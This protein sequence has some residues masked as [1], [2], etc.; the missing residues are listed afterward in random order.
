MKKSIITL[1]SFTLLSMG[2]SVRSQ[3]FQNFLGKS[4]P[5]EFGNAVTEQF[6]STFL[7]G[8]QY[9]N[10]FYGK[11]FPACIHLKK[12]GSWD[13]ARQYNLP[14]QPS[15]YVQYVEAVRNTAGT[16][17]GYIAVI[18]ASSSI[19]VA[20]LA[21]NGT[22]TWGRKLSNASSSL[23]VYRVKP[24]YS[25]R[26]SAPSFYVLAS[27]FNADEQ[28]VIKL[29]SVGSTIWQKRIGHLTS[30]NE[31]IFRDLKV[32]ADS[33]CVL[34]GYVSLSGQSQ[35]VVFK[36]TSGGSISWARQ[37]DFFST[38]Y[39]AGF[40]ITP[41]SGGY[42]V[43]GDENN[44]DD[45]L[46]FKVSTTG[47]IIWAYKYTNAAVNELNGQAVI[48]DN[49]GNIVVAGT[50]YNPTVLNDA[51]LMKLN[52]TGSV[53]FAKEYY[54]HSDVND[55][56]LT[57]SGGYI[58]TGT[59]DPSNVLSDIYVVKTN[60]SG[61]IASSCQPATVTYTRVNPE[62][63][64]SAATSYYIGN[65]VLTNTA[66]TINSP[67]ITTEEVRCG[68]ALV[69]IGQEEPVILQA[70]FTNNNTIMAVLKGGNKNGLP[71][72]A[73]LMNMNGEVI[74]E[75]VI[76]HASPVLFDIKKPQTGLY[77]LTVQQDGQTL[78]QQKIMSIQ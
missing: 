45:N 35:S 43:T 49:S 61:N 57:R 15:S 68:S 16:K 40:G 54:G 1:V 13:W 8:G 55:L 21:N 50:N 9:R 3:N 72:I 46:T 69:T 62:F 7:V 17:D 36:M 38:S 73:R 30:G 11:D 4:D 77:V 75:K 34:T 47:A 22:V 70:Y 58:F 48:E 44:G 39:A 6:D 23:L 53:L 71:Y 29:N 33:G 20:R 59:S 60:T 28:L 52:S 37:Y 63:N 32:T 24:V 14:G 2:Q 5:R 19:F 12:N 41:A 78:A 42:V 25:S 64:S 27:D 51:Y 31:Y 26:T 56:K 74:A 66:V 65:S 67:S 10:T 18:Q 76:T